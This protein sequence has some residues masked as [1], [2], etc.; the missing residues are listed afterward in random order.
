MKNL[1]SRIKSLFKNRDFEVEDWKVQFLKRDKEV[2]TNFR[3]TQN[4]EDFEFKKIKH[5]HYLVT[6]TDG[7]TRKVH[8]NDSLPITKRKIF[9]KKGFGKFFIKNKV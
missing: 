4:K 5:I 3:L 2:V 6:F 9:T 8:F 7:S 1:L